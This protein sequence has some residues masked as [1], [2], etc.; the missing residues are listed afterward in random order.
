MLSVNDDAH[1]ST[2]PSELRKSEI[3]VQSLVDAFHKFQNPFTIDQT[4][5][6]SLIC[7]SSG[8]AASNKIS[9]DLSKFREIGEI[10]LKDFI[11]TRL[12]D[13]SVKFQK[14][15]KRLKISTFEQMSTKKSVTSTQKKTVQIKAERNL[16][17]RL[18]FLSQQNDIDLEKLFKY[19]LAPI[20]WCLATADGS[21]V[22]T[23]KSS[24]MH[25][26]EQMAEPVTDLSMENAVY[27]VDGN[28]QFQA[29]TNLPTTFEDLA[30]NLFLSLPKTQIVHFVTDTYKEMS[31]KQAERSRRGDS[32]AIVIGGP[33]TKLP[34]DFKSFLLNSDN[35]K[36]FIRFLLDSWKTERYA[37]HL[38]HR[39][40]YFACED[41]CLLLSSGDG[42]SVSVTAVNELFSSQEEADTQ[43]ILHA[44]HASE[45]VPAEMKIVIRSPDTDVFILLIAYTSGMNQQVLFETGT[46]NKKRLLNIPA[47]ASAVGEDIAKALP[48]LHSF[49]G[50]DCTSAFV[51]KWKVT[52][53]KN[54]ATSA[55]IHPILQTDWKRQ[56]T[57]RR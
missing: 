45:R 40:V 10:A 38:F 3:E 26:L 24:L 25:H 50:S 1:K 8:R 21:L 13:K 20:P 15:L 7:L 5:S 32:A 27:V 42:K 36:Q 51:R 55:R 44:L 29:F 54:I 16:L 34:R 23:D 19:P 39:D 18:L 12:V 43:I 11:K 33:K 35:K 56:H 52:P 9:A 53:F 30:F 57:F 31:I 46:G 22:K 17:G 28:A 49:T 41:Q 14:P 37:K 4:N 6:E 47:I 2:R 48:G